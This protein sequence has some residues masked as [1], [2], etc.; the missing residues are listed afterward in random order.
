MILLRPLLDKGVNLIIIIFFLQSKSNHWLCFVVLLCGL[1]GFSD[2]YKAAWLQHIL[3]WQDKG[4][5]C[6]GKDGERAI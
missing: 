6:F 5:G 1:S 3:A 4:L 2:F